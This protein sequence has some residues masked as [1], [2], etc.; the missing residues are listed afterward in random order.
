V[1][2]RS[3]R[4]SEGKDGRI[5]STLS[6]N[7]THQ[8][9]NPKGI[10]VE[11]KNVVDKPVV[12][13][14]VPVVSS[15]TDFKVNWSDRSSVKEYKRRWKEGR[16]MGVNVGVRVG[17]V[18]KEV[19]NKFRNH[20]GIGKNEARLLVSKLI[21]SSVGRSPKILTLPSDMWVW[22]KLILSMK[23]ESK[24]VGV[25]YDNEIFNRM[26]KTYVDSPELQRSVVSLHNSPMCDIIRKSETDEFSHLVLDYCGI[27]N[28]FRDEINEVLTRNLVKVNGYISI[29]LSSSG[30]H[31]NDVGRPISNVL[32]ILPRDL[33]GDGMTDSVFSTK[34]I[35]SSMLVELGDRY[36]L[37]EFF[38]YNDTTEM[39]L[40]VIRRMK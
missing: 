35:I 37:D 27:I 7:K 31:N 33:F 36:K 13:P 4:L 8:K 18:K 12:V 1:Y 2:K 34:V 24:F 25:E 32:N 22:E 9:P 30:R 21:G 10:R 20:D 6:Y 26:L 29:T 15:M 16:K 14:V 28:S 17:K 38:T 11:R 23:P 39:M 3:V 5:D 19:V 40:F